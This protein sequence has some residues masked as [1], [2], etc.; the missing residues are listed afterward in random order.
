VRG[1]EP[2]EPDLQWRLF[3]PFEDTA[4]TVYCLGHAAAPVATF[5][6]PTT[7]VFGPGVVASLPE[8]F[9][10][11]KP[12]LVTDPGLMKTP[13][14]EIVRRAIGGGEAVF[15]DVQANPTEANVRAAAS[16]FRDGGCDSV[17][18]LGGGSALDVGKIVRLLARFPDKPLTQFKWDDD[19][20]GNGKLAPFCAI[21]TTAG[22]GSEVGRSSVVT[23]GRTKHVIFHPALLA[24]LVI[25][26]PA[27]T[28]D[29]PAKLTAATGR[30]RADALH[31]ELHVAGISSDVRR[32]RARGIRMTYKALPKAVKEPKDLDA[33]RPDATRRDDGRDRVP[34]GL[35]RGRTR[36]RIR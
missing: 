10:S 4:A 26:D 20:G 36:S 22:T 3:H 9:R 18:A 27:L 31:R 35:G 16:A 8:R 11:A 15:G 23:I 30:G 28:V 21:P 12:L 19:V 1:V 14:F 7:I 24:D 32:D 13:V 17:I 2:D 34:E 25:L 33:P 29:L 6:F 5:S